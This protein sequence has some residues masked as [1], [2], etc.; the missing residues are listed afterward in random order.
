MAPPITIEQN[1][2]RACNK[3]VHS[4]RKD[5]LMDALEVSALEGQHKIF[6]FLPCPESFSTG[7]LVHTYRL[8][9]IPIATLSMHQF[10]A[11]Q[12]LLLRI[13]ST[14]FLGKKHE[15]LPKRST[16]CR[17]HSGGLVAPVHSEV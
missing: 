16:L 4:T 2:V 13:Q 8:N 11:R 10:S 17:L 15:H 7:I 14:F 12:W 6:T 1:L 5:V 9:Q 3:S